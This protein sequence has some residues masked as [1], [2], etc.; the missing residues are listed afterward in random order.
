MGRQPQTSG[1]LALEQKNVIVIEAA[2]KQEAEK[3]RVAAYC[4]VS[5]N[6]TDQLN[7]FM[8]QLNYYTALIASKENWTLADLY[9][10]GC[11][12]IGLNQ[13]HPNSWGAL[14]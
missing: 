1:S 10:D 3:L 2:P 5:S 14:V 6:S 8:A 12:K 13:K 4:R 7:S 9:A 11:I